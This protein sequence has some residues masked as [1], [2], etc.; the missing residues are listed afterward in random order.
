VAIAEPL[1]ETAPQQAG[2]A[3]KQVIAAGGSEATV[4]RARR[5][6]AQVRKAEKEAKE[7]LS[8]EGFAP[9]FNGKDLS[10]WQTKEC[11]WWKVADGVLVAESTAETPLK[12]NN[13]LIWTGGTPGDFELRAEFRLSKSANSGIQLR[14]EPVTD[15][16]TGYQ[17]DMNGAGNYVGFLYH[18]K[19]HLIGGRGE[20]VTIAADGT[21]TA[22]RFAE[23]AELQRLFK[24]EDWNSYRVVCKGPEI[25][26][27][28]NGTL[29][30]QVT[31]LRADTPRQGAITLQLH[32]GPPMKIEYRNLRLKALK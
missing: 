18:P 21:K 3:L 2:D 1:A 5:A 25:T 24:V 14:A 19:M 15:R 12:T 29:T 27:Y 28:L 9:L 30:T 32:K 31:D 26:L 4:K 23:S 13:H 16:D 7:A 10:G 11:P 6:L 17:A 8:E 22:T 20:R